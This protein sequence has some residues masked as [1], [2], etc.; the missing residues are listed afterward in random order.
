M[1]HKSRNPT[2]RIE[3]DL[4]DEGWLSTGKRDNGC[5]AWPKGHLFEL[6]APLPL[7]REVDWPGCGGFIPDVKP[8]A[9]CLE[10]LLL[11]FRLVEDRLT[12]CFTHPPLVKDDSEGSIAGAPGLVR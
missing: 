12:T 9:R 5:I 4:V 2:S 7:P 1:P 8:L 11:S 3:D 6:D 10:Q